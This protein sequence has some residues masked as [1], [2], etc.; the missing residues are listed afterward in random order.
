ME[1]E[2]E[3]VQHEEKFYPVKEFE[4]SKADLKPQSCSV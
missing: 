4:I 2:A 3:T 1:K